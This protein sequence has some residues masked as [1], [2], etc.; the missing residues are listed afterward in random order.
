[1][2]CI[3]IFSIIVQLV[4][5][6]FF[7]ALNDAV[8]NNSSS[9]SDFFKWPTTIFIIIIFCGG[10]TRKINRAL[11]KQNLSGFCPA[12]V[13]ARRKSFSIDRVLRWFFIIITCNN[14][15]FFLLILLFFVN[16]FS[17]C[18]FYQF[19]S[20]I[21]RKSCVWVCFYIYKYMYT[22]YYVLYTVLY[23]I[24]SI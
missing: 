21:V 5:N 23:V 11:T 12:L 8:A 15:H 22:L 13:M 19:S 2:K 17:L 9:S 16:R 10:A 6:D 3:Y 1:M 14:F 18:I 20:C 4:L 7:S 24:H